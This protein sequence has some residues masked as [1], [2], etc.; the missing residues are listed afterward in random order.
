M[1]TTLVARRTLLAVPT[2]RLYANIPKINGTM[3]TI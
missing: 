3:P 1:T 2:M